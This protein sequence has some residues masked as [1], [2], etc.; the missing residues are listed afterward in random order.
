MKEFNVKANWLPLQKR[1]QFKDHDVNIS[2]FKAILS[3]TE[4]IRLHIHTRL[5]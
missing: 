5:L 2:A 3:K 1:S 4:T